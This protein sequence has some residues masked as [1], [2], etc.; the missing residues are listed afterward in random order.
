MND[1]INLENTD[2]AIIK[3]DTPQESVLKGFDILGGISTFINEGEK[4]FI[5]FNLNTSGGFPTNTN[6]DVIAAVIQS[7]KKA[8]AERIYLGSFPLRGV[9]IKK[10]SNLL[11]LEEYFRSIG[12]EL[13]YLD[14][15][16]LFDEKNLKEDQLNKIKTDS[17]SILKLS[18]S[19]EVTIFLASTASLKIF[20]PISVRNIT[21][22]QSSFKAPTLP[23]DIS[24][25][26]A[27]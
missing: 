1:K 11:N 21:L 12:T 5:K 27:A 26:S 10:I 23:T 3:G 18:I 17:F 8:K 6:F 19:S 22:F 25:I 15:S 9:P 20:A 7:C 13:V 4:V 14:N 16:N 2:V 24:A